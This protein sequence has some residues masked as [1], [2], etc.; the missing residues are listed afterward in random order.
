MT[1]LV[2]RVSTEGAGALRSEK[3]LAGIPRAPRHLRS[4]RYVR[5]FTKHA[6]PQSTSNKALGR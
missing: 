2:S 6:Y 4:K 5:H 1:L 3:W